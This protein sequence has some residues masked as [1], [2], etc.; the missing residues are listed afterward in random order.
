VVGVEVHEPAARAA[1]A[2]YEQVLALPVEDALARLEPGFDTILLYDVLEHVADPAPVLRGL[3]ALG[4]PGAT[5]HVS[6]PNARHWTLLRD[7][8]LR[9]T[10]GYADAG[11]R[12]ATHLRWFT[13]GDLVA[14]LETTGWRV[15]RTAHAPL[16]PL[17]AAAE[18]LTR[19]LTAEFLV[20]Q[21]S[22]LARAPRSAPA[23]G[24]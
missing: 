17:S 22:A 5:L 19:G 23:A 12:D 13:R 6:V 3:L 20:Y 16:R 14:L 4:A 24:P 2:A 1:A 21:W 7:L 8:T 18:R 11:H 10:F 9:G 15:E